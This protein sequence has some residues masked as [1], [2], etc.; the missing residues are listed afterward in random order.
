MGLFDSILEKLGGGASHAAP[1]STAPTTPPEASTGGAGGLAT[2]VVDQ[3]ELAARLDA[4]AGNH[5]R[6]LNWR[7]SIVD[8]LELLGLDSSLAARQQL[9][10]ELGCA[11]ERQA[12]P[13]ALDLC[14]HKA[15][16]SRLLD[17]GGRP[18]D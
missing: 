18:P 3:V 10:G 17:D 5:P 12:D 9:A 7:G 1:A 14:L 13:A 15:L 2:P 16:M 4:L 11:A 6:R 8:L